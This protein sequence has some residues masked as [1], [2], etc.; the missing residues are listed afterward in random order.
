M[1]IPLITRLEE[2]TLE[3]LRK[4]AKGMI[5]AESD[6]SLGEYMNVPPEAVSIALKALCY[7]KYI[8]IEFIYDLVRVIHLN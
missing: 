3:A 8:S 7:R 1:I 6:K 5:V 2:K 4:H